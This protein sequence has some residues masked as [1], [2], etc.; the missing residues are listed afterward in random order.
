[1]PQ[2]VTQIEAKKTDARYA[3]VLYAMEPEVILDWS[4]DGDKAREV[5]AQIIAGNG[6][7]F[8][9]PPFTLTHFDH[10]CKHTVGCGTREPAFEALRMV[11]GRAENNTFSRHP[12]TKTAP[13]TG[14][15]INWR[16]AAEKYVFLVTDEDSDCPYYDVNRFSS[17]VWPYD[18][19]SGPGHIVSDNDKS[20]QPTRFV[21]NNTVWPIDKMPWALES[22]ATADAIVST[23]A[24]VSIFARPTNGLTLGQIGDPTNRTQVQKLDFS[25]FNP[26]ATLDRLRSNGYGRSLQAQV[27]QAQLNLGVPADMRLFD[28]NAIL[29]PNVVDNFF[30][31]VVRSIKSACFG[32]KRDVDSS[33]LDTHRYAEGLLR[34]GLLPLPLPRGGDAARKRAINCQIN[35][36]D[37]DANQCRATP[38]CDEMSMDCDNCIIPDPQGGDDIC[39][40]DGQVNPANNCQVCNYFTAPNQ[41]LDA[42]DDRDPCTDDTCVPGPDGVNV[43]KHVDKCTPQCGKCQIG[44]QCVSSGIVN[45]SNRCYMCN[46][47]EGQTDEDGCALAGITDMSQCFSYN[48]WTKIDPPPENVPG[49]QACEP[50]TLNCTC[51]VG[52]FCTSPFMGNVVTC[53]DGNCLIETT[54]APTPAPPPTPAPCLGEA[55]DV[56]CPCLANSTC[57][58]PTLA[59]CAYGRCEL[60]QF[61]CHLHGKLDERCRFVN[62]PLFEEKGACDDGLMCEGIFCV[63]ATEPPAT[64]APTPC[65]LGAGGCPCRADGSC[66]E[67]LYCDETTE[68]CQAYA[69]ELGSNGCFCGGENMDQ[70]SGELTCD[71]L[72]KKCRQCLVGEEHC[73]CQAGGRCTGGASTLVCASG[74][75]ID[76]CK[77]PP[78]QTCCRAGDL[79]CVCDNGRC[80]DPGVECSIYDFCDPAAEAQDPCVKACRALVRQCEHGALSCSCDSGKPE[81]DCH[82]EPVEDAEQISSLDAAA[83]TSLA[84]AVLAIAAIA[85]VAT[86]L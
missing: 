18:Q 48:A 80:A 57:T 53:Q 86:L 54:P 71:R 29:S 65:S 24:H 46:P 70:C 78:P 7:N 36:C 26:Q 35:F 39:V 56:D 59:I 9:R 68:T 85:A 44:D 72:T 49:C 5:M 10:D 62:H 25:D 41:W 16:P 83:H 55:G 77:L 1:M 2:F 15:G 45:L 63:P 37:F 73:R 6:N 52:D 3:V 81:V 58:V 42:C 33:L 23:G 13:L 60:C 66:D 47:I 84:A 74:R 50:G 40:F 69:C 31:E 30:K 67:P 38:R 21:E 28:T 20:Y 17:T 61:N 76:T 27:L 14:A 43:C 22:T 11:L 32:R 4:V 75:C 19:C 12:Q 34:D 64:P 51:D 8:L 82:T 79:H